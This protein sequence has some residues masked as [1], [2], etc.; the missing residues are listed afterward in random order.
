M[1]TEVKNQYWIGSLCETVSYIPVVSGLACMIHLIAIS[2]FSDRLA[3]T[4][5][6]GSYFEYLGRYCEFEHHADKKF[7]HIKLQE[8]FIDLFPFGRILSAFMSVFSTKEDSGKKKGEEATISLNPL[9]QSQRRLARD[10][11]AALHDESAAGTGLIDH[12]LLSHLNKD[13]TENKITEDERRALLN[14]TAVISCDWKSFFSPW[15]DE[16]K[17]VIKA[18]FAKYFKERARNDSA[19]EELKGTLLGLYRPPEA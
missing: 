17:E 8:V 13:K 7:S 11:S 19:Y 2:L 12:V 10:E 4:Q 16:N 14:A 18:A 1:V 3:Q 5:N 6:P 15:I 9:H